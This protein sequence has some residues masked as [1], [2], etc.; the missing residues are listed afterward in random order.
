MT[1]KER[2]LTALEHREPD[3]VPYDLGATTDTG[4]HHICYRKLLQYTEKEDL[5]RGA[6]ALRFHHHSSS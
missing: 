4:I 1:S 3:R 5:I 6:S 2:I